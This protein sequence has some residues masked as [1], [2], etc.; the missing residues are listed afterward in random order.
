MVDNCTFERG[1]CEC[2]CTL[3]HVHPGTPPPAL[4]PLGQALKKEGGVRRPRD[5]GGRVWPCP[6]AQQAVRGRN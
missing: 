6:N 4:E 1:E 3:M 5:P 2:V